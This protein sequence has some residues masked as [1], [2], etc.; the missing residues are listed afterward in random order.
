[1]QLAALSVQTAVTYCS[2]TSSITPVNWSATYSAVF[3]WPSST[4]ARR[5]GLLLLPHFHGYTQLSHFHGLGLCA[6]SVHPPCSLLIKYHMQT[7]VDGS[8]QWAQSVKV[9]K[10]Q[11]SGLPALCCAGRTGYDTKYGV[12]LRLRRIGGLIRRIVQL[13][14]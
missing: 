10:L 13:R 9:Q 11:V 3:T 14:H 7:S 1:V 8:R 12:L 2:P 6:S 4:E 5:I